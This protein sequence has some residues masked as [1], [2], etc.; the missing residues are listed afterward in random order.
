MPTTF[1]NKTVAITGAANGL[2]A[3]LA[4]AFLAQGAS[5]ALSDV[6]ASLAERWQD[7][8]NV[9]VSV[10]DVTDYAAVTAWA[11][12]VQSRFS[13]CDI[14]INN[15]GITVLASFEDHRIEDWENVLG[16]NLWGPIYC[17]KAFLPMLQRSRGQLVNISSAFG[18]V[19]PPGQAAYAASK[20]AIRGIS[21]VLWEE[22]RS[23]DVA[24]TVVHPGGIATKIAESSLVRNALWA[25]HVQKTIIPFFEQKTMPA[26]KA[27]RLIIRAIE[28]RKPRLLIGQEAWIFDVLKRLFPVLGNY[29]VYRKL[30]QTFDLAEME[31]ENGRLR[32]EARGETER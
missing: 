20:Y 6:D 24:V 21:E 1:T 17:T 32:P 14:L 3:A 31:D 9:L 26:T 10:V 8:S 23:E 30:H 22:L 2:G 28:R 5:L 29:L 4:E 27:A 15:A 11:N 7:H 12:E 18:I 19:A 16:V 25:Q 13:G